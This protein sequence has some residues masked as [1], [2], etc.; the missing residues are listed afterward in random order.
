MYHKLKEGALLIADAHYPNHQKEQFIKLL[1][2]ILLKKIKITQ[3][4]LVG[5]IFDLL[6]GNSPYLKKRFKKEIDKL[7]AIAKDIDVIYL[8][9][10]HDFYLKP[11]FKNIK[12]I[13]INNQPYITTLNNKKVAIS[14]GDKFNTPII[15][16]IYT[17]VIRN[18]IILKILP[19]KIAKNKL[20][21]MQKK[22]IC[23][24][25]PNFKKYINN[26][27][28]YNNYDIIIEGHYHQ[29]KIIQNYY[30]MP[31]F[32]CNKEVAIIKNGEIKY[33]NLKDI[34]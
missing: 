28:K 23:K 20:K 14:H 18:P 25:L 5:D 32:A 7:N 10:N 16:K 8:E 22:S 4:I 27:K 2:A 17:K 9:G 6:V 13:P 12:I 31:S 11:L 30:A 33:I 26:I 19:D 15:Y 3:L 1:D 29:G 24:K 21:S 34:F